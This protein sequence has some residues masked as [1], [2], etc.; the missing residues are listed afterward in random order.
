MAM[1]IFD[2]IKENNLK[3][4]I[5]VESKEEAYALGSIFNADHDG[6]EFAKIYEY[7]AVNGVC[8][9]KSECYG[10]VW[11]H[12]EESFYRANINKKS[13]TVMGNCY[14]YKIYNFKDISMED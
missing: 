1:S 9:F 8:C 2:Q 4:I 7:Y 14:G 11:G 13:N 5:K 6:S 10:R 12:S 3:A